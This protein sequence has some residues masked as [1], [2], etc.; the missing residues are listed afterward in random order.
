MT[1]YKIRT[2]CKTCGRSTTSTKTS[3]CD[4]CWGVESRLDTY[5]KTDRG[6]QV[7]IQKLD[8]MVDLREMADEYPD[9]QDEYPDDQDDAL[10]ERDPH[11]GEQQDLKAHVVD[12]PPEALDEEGYDCIDQRTGIK[13]LT[14]LS[15]GM[16]CDLEEYH[17][18]GEC[19][20]CHAVNKDD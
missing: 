5:L 15:C 1:Q 2:A 3:R 18:G 7:I 16:I 8:S 9:D 10:Y 14:C 20:L 11:Y 6:V 19:N 13:Y 4:N 12:L 17:S